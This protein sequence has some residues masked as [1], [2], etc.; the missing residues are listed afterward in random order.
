[1]KYFLQRIGKPLLAGRSVVTFPFLKDKVPVA[2]LTY[3]AQVE[4]NF[5]RML[6]AAGAEGELPVRL[7]LPLASPRVRKRPARAG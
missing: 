6:Q 3:G 7:P 5:S 4:S 1:M 2:V